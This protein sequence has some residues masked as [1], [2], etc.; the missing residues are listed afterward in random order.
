M[1]SGRLKYFIFKYIL[2]IFSD[3]AFSTFWRAVNAWRFRTPF[4]NNVFAKQG[5]FNH[6]I[7]TF[8]ESS[9]FDL[10]QPIADKWLVR[11]Y[12]SQRIGEEYLVPL[13]AKFESID[14]IYLDDSW[15]PCVLKLNKGSG[16][17]LFLRDGRT[18]SL[19]S[20]K[21]K[22]SWWTSID[23][24]YFTR[25]RHYS[26]IH[27][28][29]LV[30]KSLGEGIEDFK[31]FCFQSKAIYIQVDHGR[32]TN[33]TRSFYNIDWSPSSILL[34]YQPVPF[35]I[36]KPDCLDE[37]LLLAEKL[38]KDFAFLRVD[39]YFVDNRLYVGEL[40]FF[41]EGGQ[42]VFHNPHDDKRLGDLIISDRLLVNTQSAFQ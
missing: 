35:E 33:H 28:V 27:P 36:P 18:F 41:P 3:H 15:F 9:E 39:F 23:P 14:D 42:G 20:V 5:T 37:M 22:F 12:L 40:T 25:E 29:V 17:N 38:A 10:L 24:F 34:N 26:K 1:L 32:F 6:K 16:M 21:R 19:E 31:V 13:Y 8:K 11:K 2:G 7:N 4:W 30:E